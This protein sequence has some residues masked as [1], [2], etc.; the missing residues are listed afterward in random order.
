[1]FEQKLFDYKKIRLSGVTFVIRKLTPDLFLDKEYLFPI[2]P[3][4][5]SIKQTGKPQKANELEKQL[6]EQKQRI[7][8]II[9]QSVVSVH[10][11]FQKK[12][13]EDLIDGIMEREF[14]YSALLTAI[15]QHTLGVKKN[16]FRLFQS[17]ETLRP[18]FSK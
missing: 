9:I 16:Y 2:S 4:V 8:E 15:T 17:T 5:E 18:L 12:K 10:Y 14:L 1:M 6:A 11:W 3:Y 13:I 7:K